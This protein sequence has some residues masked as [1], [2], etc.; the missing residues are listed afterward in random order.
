[1]GTRL[2]FLS[3]DAAE[4]AL[5]AVLRIMA[6]E[7]CWDEDRIEQEK[8]IALEVIRQDMGSSKTRSRPEIK[9]DAREIECYTKK[10][11]A[12]DKDGKGYLTPEDLEN[13]TE[14]KEEEGES[15]VELLAAAD[16]N[17]NGKLELDEFLILMSDMKSGDV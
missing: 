5:P 11:C 3:C 6:K 4:E 7:L 16:L 14:A 2:A 9:L 1:M 13:L 12:A 8:Q 10:F 17:K 15:L